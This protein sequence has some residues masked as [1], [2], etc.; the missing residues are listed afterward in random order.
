ML[1]LLAWTI[2]VILF[3]TSCLHF[4]WA[5]GSVW[6]A[7]SEAELTLMVVGIEGVETMPSRPL[8]ATVALG[9]CLVGIIPLMWR[10]LIPYPHAIPQTLV[11]IAMWVL[12][13]L[14]L[15]RGI[16]GLLPIFPSQAMPFARLNKR[17]FSPLILASGLG[18]LI[19]VLMP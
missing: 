2:A 11:W 4:A 15:L 13:A 5:A 8:T 7:G 6:P 3:A 1:E 12:A 9:I 10:G 19:L 17:Y 14:F 16:A 18:Y